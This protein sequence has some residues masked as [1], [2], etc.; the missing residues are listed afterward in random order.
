ML[1]S[2]SLAFQQEFIKKYADIT[3]HRRNVDYLGATPVH[4]KQYFQSL[5]KAAAERAVRELSIYCG[6]NSLGLD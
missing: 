3:A 2:F 6:M 5:L 1:Q 4:H